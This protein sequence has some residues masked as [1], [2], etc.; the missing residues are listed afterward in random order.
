VRRRWTPGP[1]KYSP[2]DD[3]TYWTDSKTVMAE[4]GAVVAVETRGWGEEAGI[5]NAQLIAAAPDLYEALEAIVSAAGERE[6]ALHVWLNYPEKPVRTP[7]SM[8]RA[9]LAKARGEKTDAT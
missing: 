5:A 9:A 7:G 1:W 4:D 2:D 3:D 8:A 6:D